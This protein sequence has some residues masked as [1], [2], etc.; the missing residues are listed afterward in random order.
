MR[1]RWISKGEKGMPFQR[2]LFRSLGLCRFTHLITAHRCQGH[3]RFFNRTGGIGFPYADLVLQVSPP[4]VE[5][6]TIHVRIF[7]GIAVQDA[8]FTI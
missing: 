8:I 5:C 2:C 1:W 4:E 3:I 6:S 7:E